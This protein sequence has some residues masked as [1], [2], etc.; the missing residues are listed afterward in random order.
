VRMHE[1]IHTGLKPYKCA[2]C[3]FRCT[4]GGNLRCHERRHTG[5]KPFKCPL[6]PFAAV[7]SNSV[8]GHVRASHPE[9]PPEL[10]RPI[11][12]PKPQ[13]TS[14]SGLAH[15]QH[16][17]LA[18]DTDT[19]PV[20][21]AGGHRTA[22]QPQSASEGRCDSEAFLS[23][24]GDPRRTGL[25]PARLPSSW[26]GAQAAGVRA[27][28]TAAVAV[29]HRS[30]PVP[31]PLAWG[32]YAGGASPG[33]GTQVGSSLTASGVKDAPS[34]RQPKA[35]SLTAGGQRKEGTQPDVA[36]GCQWV[37]ASVSHGD[38]QHEDTATA[39]DYEATV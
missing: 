35:P 3:D 1:W 15:W 38:G 32:T 2:Y 26:P 30:L 36:A 31:A 11:V 24:S 14:T 18:L 21:A 28:V 22:N 4:Q 39:A 20:A 37:S 16:G 5:E 23:Q 25:G 34:L 17:A 9:A 33:H 10:Q 12:D 29:K 19:L 13:A 7:K 8:R 6:C 27:T